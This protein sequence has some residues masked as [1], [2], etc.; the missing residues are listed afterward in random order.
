MPGR[1]WPCRACTAYFY[2]EHTI[3][4]TLQA[5]PTDSTFL[6]LAPSKHIDLRTTIY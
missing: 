5:A 6:T 2:E 4:V 1:G 3:W